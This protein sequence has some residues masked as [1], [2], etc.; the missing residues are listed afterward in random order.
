MLKIDLQPYAQMMI[1]GIDEA[2]QYRD[3]IAIHD[4][5]MEMLAKVERCVATIPGVGNPDA[6]AVSREIITQQH[7]GYDVE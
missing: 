4:P 6:I 1:P 7:R 5:L 2:Q 3:A